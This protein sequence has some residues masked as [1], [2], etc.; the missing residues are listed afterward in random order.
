MHALLLYLRVQRSR[1]CVF[2]AKINHEPKTC[3]IIL[4]FT[5]VDVP[6]FGVWTT[7]YLGI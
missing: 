5:L 3:K 2:H 6:S 1:W 4:W 7:Y